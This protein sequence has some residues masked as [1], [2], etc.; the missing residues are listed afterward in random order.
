MKTGLKM[1][2]IDKHTLITIA[3]MLLVKYVPPMG[4]ITPL[5]MEILGIFLGMLYGWTF[6]S[7]IWP[8]LLGMILIGLSDYATSVGG[9]L[10]AGAGHQTVLFLFFLYIFCGAIDSSGLTEV[11]G[12]YFASLKIGQ[13]RPYVLAL[14]I[15]FAA[16]LMGSLVSAVAA[17]I[18]LWQVFNKICHQLGYRRGEL[19]PKLVIIGILYAAMIGSTIFPFKVYP[20]I[21]LGVYQATTGEM[22]SF[23]PYTMFMTVLS[24]LLVAFYILLCKFVFRPSTRKG[25]AIIEP[26]QGLTSYQKKILVVMVFMIGAFFAPGLLP[27]NWSII[28]L[29]KDLGNNGIVITILIICLVLRDQGKPLLDIKTA[30]HSSMSWDIYFLVMAAFQLSDALVAEAT[31]IKSFIVGALGGILNGQSVMI[32]C[33]VAIALG[34]ILA[35][36]ISNVVMPMIII[37]LIMPFIAEI[38]INPAILICLLCVVMMDSIIMPSG[39]PVAGLLLAND[40][41]ETKDVYRYGIIILMMT[42]SICIII[43]VPLGQIFF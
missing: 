19:Y 22:I 42:I 25:T 33:A 17:A 26:P 7:M 37:P 20:I 35:N 23:L 2:R 24:L 9:I 15:C 34:G 39:S 27:D 11:I 30:I 41:V 16:W 6:C 40:W 18:L 10:A 1:A 5:G 29:L 8:S 32:F 3:L 43:G 38:G 21:M 31:G 28:G 36:I 4:D 12:Q 13:G 14:L